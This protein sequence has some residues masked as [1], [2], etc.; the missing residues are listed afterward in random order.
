LE[1][2]DIK[3]ISLNKEEKSKYIQ[4]KEISIWKK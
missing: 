2:K 3:A 1:L 4:V